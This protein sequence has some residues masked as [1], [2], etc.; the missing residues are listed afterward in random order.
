MMESESVEEAFV[1]CKG[2]IPFFSKDPI[3]ALPDLLEKISLAKNA[4]ALKT[5]KPV[6]PGKHFGN[7]REL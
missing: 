3:K 5:E 7:E 4:R 6:L 2:A 1:I